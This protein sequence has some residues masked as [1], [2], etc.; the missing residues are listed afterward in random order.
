MQ[1]RLTAVVPAL[2]ASAALLLP[3][4]VSA[5]VTIDWVTIGNPGNAND[6]SGFGAVA[7]TYRISAYEVTIGQY[8]EFLN[9]K[10]QTDTHNL[11]NPNMGSNANIA[12]IS[13]SGSPG[14]YTYSVIGTSNRPVTYVSWFDAARFSNW[15]HNGQGTGDTESG[16]YALNGATTGVSFSAS[17]SASY[18]LPTENEWYKAAYYDPTLNAGAGG[19]WLYPTQS[20]SLSGNTQGAGTGRANYN[21]GDYAVTQS[22]S[23]SASQNY[24]T[25]VGAYSD[26]GSYYGTFDQGGNVWEW[27][28][29]VSSSSRGLRGGSWGSNVFFGLQSSDR[30]NLSPAYE[31]DKLGFRLATSV[32]EPSSVLMVGLAGLALVTR[33]RRSTL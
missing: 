19:Y 24:L 12:G 10:A 31:D 2:A 15:M 26:S 16:A 21:D 11:Y 28:D 3:T 6:T 17:A 8:T 5:A 1:P 33:R 4:G 30:L 14:G 7:D 25:G 22:G 18:R 20:N 13:R 27:N 23:Y 29:A 32:P 9:A